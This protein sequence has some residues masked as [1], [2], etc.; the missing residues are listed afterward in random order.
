MKRIIYRYNLPLESEDG[1]LT[2]QLFEKTLPWSEAGLQILEQE[3]HL[4]EYTVED[5]GL[6]EPENDSIDEVLN[7]LLGVTE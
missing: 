1:T 7:V 6:P 2:E 3:A 5:D 4:G